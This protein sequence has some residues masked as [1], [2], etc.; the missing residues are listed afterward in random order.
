[1][2]Q[3]SEICGVYSWPSAWRGDELHLRVETPDDRYLRSG[4]LRLVVGPEIDGADFG[5][6]AGQ[7]IRV[8]AFLDELTGGMS[9]ESVWAASNLILS[10]FETSYC[11]DLPSE[12]CAHL[13]T[14][15]FE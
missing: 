13:T 6:P 9:S 7:R 5:G 4:V 8:T 1:M 14:K 12:P 11:P 3:S 2:P 10:S 15:P